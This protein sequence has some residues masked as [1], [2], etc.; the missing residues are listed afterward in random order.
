MSYNI[1]KGKVRKEIRPP[2]RDV[3]YVRLRPYVLS[4]IDG[5]LTNYSYAISGTNSKKWMIVMLE[6]VEFLC[7]ND[8]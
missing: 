1:V 7:T 6:G 5:E 3:N 8:T 2:L 4:T